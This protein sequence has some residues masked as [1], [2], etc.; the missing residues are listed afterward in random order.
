MDSPRLKIVTKWFSQD[1]LAWFRKFA[2][3]F[4][5]Y[6]IMAFILGYSFTFILPFIIGLIIAKSA[7]PLIAWVQNKIR[8]SRGLA[9]IFVTILI[10]L[11]IFGIIGGIGFIAGRELIILIQRIPE[12]NPEKLL[13]AFEDWAARQTGTFLFLDIGVLM[14]NFRDDILAFLSTG[15]NWIGT[16]GAGLLSLISSLPI[17]ITLVIVVI[18]STFYFSRDFLHLKQNIGFIFSSYANQNIK[19][20]WKDG[21]ITMGKYIRSYLLIYL[22]TGILS[23]A[24][25]ALLGIPYA[26]VW[27]ILVAIFDV[28]PI[29]GPGVVYVP[30]A[31]YFLIAG[32][33]KIALFLAIGLIVVMVVRQVIEPRIV[34]KSINI[35]PLSMLAIL[36]VSFQT[37]NINVM[38]Y[39]LFL[40]LSYN[41][42][43][44][45]NLLKP[46]FPVDPT[47]KKKRKIG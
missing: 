42:L 13:Q 7:Q 16:I 15:Q 25:F 35:H 17:W 36:L 21:L 19:L 18:V 40:M 33:W 8:L 28:L 37:H 43:K 46:L 41:L 29:L 9:S 30:M 26:L 4:I 32:D 1:F 38:F 23:F 44:N 22:L 11:L 45:V 47:H 12:I 10:L 5:A 31:I 14:T 2:L 39:L 27:S 20:A 6:T 24:L 34:A 3:F